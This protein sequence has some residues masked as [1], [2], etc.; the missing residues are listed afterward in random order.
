[1]S[2]ATGAPRR[3]TARPSQV[4]RALGDHTRRADP[5]TIV[6]LGAHGDLA[7]RKLL[8]AI[9]Q[10]AKDKLLPAG[11]DVLGVARQ[12]M[13]DDAFRKMMLAAVRD[14]DEI[15]EFDQRVWD[16]L[17]P[18]IHYAVADLANASS[19][20]A[21]GERLAAVESNRDSEDHNRLFYLAVPPSV[22]SPIVRALSESGLAPRTRGDSDRPWYRVVIE[23][24]F[25]R[26]LETALG[27]NR[28]VLELFDECQLYRIDHYLGKETVQSILVFRFAN[29]IFEPI[30]NRQSISHVQITVA[31]TV[32]VE[33]RGKY[34][35]EAGVVR[36]MFQNHL[37]QLLTLTAMEPP[38]M[39]SAD[40]V[41]DEKVKVLQSLRWL[42][43]QAIEHAAVR[44]Q[45]A[46]G[47]VDGAQAKGYREEADVAK[48]SITPTYAAITFHV[49][50]WRWTGVPFFLRS[51]KRLPRR[52]SEIAVQFR[53][54]PVLMF[55]REAREQIAPNV[56][57]MRIQPNEGVSLSFQVKSPGAAYQLSK[58]IEVAPV[59]MDFT[60]S[61]AFGDVNPPAYE[62]LLLDVMLGD[63]TLFTRSDEV[64]AAWRVVDPIIDYWEKHPPAAM[65]TYAAGT[66]GPAEADLLV[67]SHDV[68]WR[69]PG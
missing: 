19:Y 51:G 7:Q 53:E 41:R 17:A 6:I 3:V 4:L 20:K 29:A 39:M 65:P 60:Y 61:E 32:G 8:P 52:V 35:E 50:N 37:L 33:Q 66:W 5:C 56:L 12:K 11:T 62:T 36:D 23:K 63:A 16:A 49:D 1:M 58:G 27:L 30:W 46:A 57:T 18:R 40:A 14:S 67:E 43:G 59:A 45:Y 34:Y 9:Y 22:F 10:L 26:S 69:E 28:L 48:S 24:P 44:A 15:T 54:P 38:A 25:G 55:R 31:E 21:L 68:A 47:S 13:D 2:V 42:H 64:E